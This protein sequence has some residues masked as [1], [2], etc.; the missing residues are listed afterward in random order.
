M[1]FVSLTGQ[2]TITINGSSPFQSLGDENVVELTFPNN[3]AEIKTGKNGNSV[4]SFNTP[5]AH[6]DVKIRVIRGA[7][8]D[9]Y[10]QSLLNLQVN[11]FAN[12][13]LLFGVFTKNVGDGT[14]SVIADT[15]ILS[16]GVFIKQIEAKSNVAGEIDQSICVYQM[17]FASSPRALIPGTGG[18]GTN[19]IR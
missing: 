10:L 3:M 11:A 17:Q 5:G 18:F 19:R 9:V 2:D 7:V 12:F 13:P 8:D 1:A 15:Y 4:Y 16:G 14:G 6:A